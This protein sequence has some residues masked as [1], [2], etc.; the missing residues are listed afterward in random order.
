MSRSTRFSHSSNR[1]KAESPLHIGVN[2]EIISKNKDDLSRSNSRI[3]SA[4]IPATPRSEEEILQSTNLKC[5]SFNELKTATRNFRPDSVVGEGGFG[6]VFKGWIDEHSLAPARPGT[7]TTMAH[8]AGMFVVPQTIGHVLCPKCGILMTTN[9]ANMCV[10]CLAS[11]VD[12]TDG[13]QKHRLKLKDVRLVHAEFVWTEPN[14][15]RMIVRLRIQKEVLRGAVLEKAY[16]VLYVEHRQMCESYSR[17]QANPDQWVAAVQLRQHVRHRRAFFYLEQLILKH[18]AAAQAIWIKQMDHGIDF[19]FSS[20]SHGVKFIEFVGKVA[21]L[22]PSTLR[23]CFLDADR[24]WRTLFKCLLSS[25]QLVEYIVLDIDVISL[26]VNV[27]GS[28]THLGHLLNPGDYALGYDLYGANNN[29]SE[30]DKYKGLVLPDAILIKKSYEETC[31]RKCG[32]S[33]SWK[34]KFLNM[35]ID[36][37]T[38]GRLEPEKM[39]SEHEEFLRDL[40]E[41]PELRFNIS[42]YCNKEYWPL[43]VASMTD[44][45]DAPMP[46]EELLDELDISDDGED[47]GDD[48]M[49][50]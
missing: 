16:E 31:Q 41:N 1:I 33:H 21:P 35:E 23:Y 30:L 36:N 28:R 50:E 48:G 15:M 20:R 19:F 25:R 13:L 46:L 37:S 10:K 12:I 3:S 2:S 5:F 26:E 4:S 27:P 38:R 45:D 9:A 11:E 32:K 14:S 43:E 34:L 7:F 22:D 47:A 6:A 44:R 49:R 39:N 40:E 24:Y 17:S 8:E 42:L 29:D 18:D